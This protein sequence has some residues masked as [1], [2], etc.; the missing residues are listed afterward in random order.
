MT[1]A[2]LTELFDDRIAQYGQGHFNFDESKH[3][4][5]QPT[6]AGEFVE[7]LKQVKKSVEP[8]QQAAKPADSLIE[9]L[10]KYIKPEQIERI[11]DLPPLNMANKA[12][13]MARLNGT[14]DAE[15]D[16][17]YREI[18]EWKPEAVAEKP[19]VKPEAL[20]E[21]KP[22]PVISRDADPTATLPLND[23]PQ[24]D[25]EANSE[26]DPI[27]D[28]NPREAARARLK[29]DADA[30]YA[31]ARTSTV[32]NA[33][34]DLLGSAR[35]KRNWAG[36]AEAEKNG[37]AEE[38]VTRDNLLKNEPHAIM[39]KLENENGMTSLAMHLAL[40][41]FP[42]AP[43]QK[44]HHYY[45]RQK[46]DV[47]KQYRENYV[48]AYQLLKSKAEEL[49]KRPNGDL[50]VV[51]DE[52]ASAIAAEASRI[53]QKGLQY[54]PVANGLYK[55]SQA[56]SPRTRGASKSVPG[57]TLDFG[58]RMKA[59]YG[60]EAEKW[61]ENLSKHAGDVIEGD[62]FNKTFGTKGET[63]KRDFDPV[64]LYVT[65]AEREG[66][67]PV[68]HDVKGGTAF[69]MDRLKMRGLQ[70]G[71]YVSD[72]ERK[73]HLTHV[74]GAFA[75]L[76]DM[77][78]L[79]PEDMSLDGKLG[80][81]IGAR[82]HAGALAH[83]EPNTKVI[84]LTR[85][86]GVGTIAHEWG[87]FFD[88]DLAGGKVSA[89]GGDYKSNH[90][91]NQR[92]ALDEHGRP[93]IENKKLV[94]EDLTKDPMHVAFN[95]FRDALKSS[96]FSKRLSGVL[97]AFR[98]RGMS[99][100]KREYWRSG[101]EVFARSFERYVQHKLK[102]EG[103]ENTY[104]SGYGSEAHWSGDEG[105]KLG[106]QLWPTDDEIA[107]MAPHFDK[108][109]EEYRKKKYGTTDVQQYSREQ[110][111][112]DFILEAFT[113]QYAAVD[114]PLRRSIA[115]AA[116]E[117]DTEPTFAEISAGNYR[118]G[119]FI[120]NGLQIVIENPAGSTRKG[121]AADGHC[122]S[123]KMPFSYGY[124]SAHFHRGVQMGADDQ[125]VDC[126]L[127]DDPESELIF[128][129]DQNSP[130]GR[131][132]EHKL[133][134]FFHNEAEAREAYLSSYAPGW[135]G[136]KAITSM[137]LPEFRRWLEDGDTRR[138][139]ARY[140]LACMFQDAIAQYA[141]W[142]EKKHPRGQP[143]NKG[144]F[145]NKSGEPPFRDE[146]EEWEMP[147][148][149]EMTAEDQAM[150]RDGEARRQIESAVASRGMHRPAGI[151]V[152]SD[153]RVWSLADGRRQLFV[154]ETH[155]ILL[156]STQG[157]QQWHEIDDAQLAEQAQKLKI[158]TKSA[159]PAPHPQAAAKPK[160]DQPKTSGNEPSVAAADP[161]IEK[162]RKQAQQIFPVLVSKLPT[163]SKFKLH[164]L[165]GATCRKNGILFAKHFVAMI[166][167]DPRFTPVVQIMS[168]AQ[169]EGRF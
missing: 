67:R 80:L 76:A 26:P 138:P 29:A 69:V 111:I 17:L 1:Q 163:E 45:G 73:E 57:L 6:N 56:V 127:G 96:G 3:P 32:R 34:E 82:G 53:R 31:F 36:L 60:Q 110:F 99:D 152:S 91:S 81:A 100:K 155:V 85:K 25:T 21:P 89:S 52:M 94:T 11:K 20:A 63:A 147:P 70:W 23:D 140:A 48:E 88:H 151:E 112:H 30:E 59:K 108:I 79:K 72:D 126:F 133:C 158:I 150:E 49:A 162:A 86:G 97:S 122:W 130:D 118:K 75:D 22:E 65:V 148:R 8:E 43:F 37:T 55:M 157:Q 149:P 28:D 71:N 77:L 78:G 39:A 18:R 153:D 166:V 62:S 132:D 35:H 104:L 16:K 131:F 50:V 165:I 58:N 64:A 27:E 167:A 105:A 106:A 161:A 128:V 164:E 129:V 44:D 33:G 51:M 13:A 160:Q 10:K 123:Q 141:E 95:G 9:R 14:N 135:R 41:R 169:R 159:T 119:R 137:T 7:A 125:Q 12:D 136:L 2:D 142:D 42:P 90:L 168:P 117:T 121:C 101:H 84:N 139:V 114:A 74:A 5:G 4:R 40:Q 145:V 19:E 109:F 115:E 38:L 144:E 143:E 87:H 113:A 15:F 24:E 83:Y 47:K 66:G 68:P 120:W 92:M 46:E 154:R 61:T 103:R 146:D 156:D 93:K 102:D 116:S 107:H 134:L 54:D 124:L 98:E